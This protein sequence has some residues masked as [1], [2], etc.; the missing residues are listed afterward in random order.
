MHSSNCLR[1]PTDQ[2]A[3]EQRARKRQQL[4]DQISA[5]RLPETNPSGSFS[6]RSGIKERISEASQDSLLDKEMSDD[7][8]AENSAHSDAKMSS[9]QKDKDLY[10]VHDAPPL[11]SADQKRSYSSKSAAERKEGDEAIIGD[12]PYK[13]ARLSDFLGEPAMEDDT[14]GTQAKKNAARFGDGWVDKLRP[15]GPDFASGAAGAPAKSMRDKPVN[16][17]RSYSNIAGAQNAQ[18]MDNM[19]GA[20]DLGSQK[21]RDSQTRFKTDRNDIDVD[22]EMSQKTFQKDQ[23]KRGDSRQNLGG[24]DYRMDAGKSERDGNKSKATSND[25]RGTI[26]DAPAARKDAVQ[27]RQS[28]ILD[29]RRMG[30]SDHL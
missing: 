1:Y 29:D 15:S 19:S 24:D 14:K 6:A 30:G 9:R 12:S 10:H 27:G 26:S 11:K 18:N 2:Q 7:F 28:R 4:N 17:K 13:Q 5:G 3:E 16:A 22:E 25:S 21:Q 8:A 20:N 23:W